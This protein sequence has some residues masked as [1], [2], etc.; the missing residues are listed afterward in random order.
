ML[1]NQNPSDKRK[2][3]KVTLDP[4][5]E[6]IELSIK[7]GYIDSN[8]KFIWDNKSPE[9]IRIQNIPD[10]NINQID[11]DLIVDV[12]KQV[13]LTK[14]PLENNQI[15]IDDVSQDHVS[16]VLVDCSD[17]VENDVVTVSYY[18]SQAG[19]DW[20]NEA[21]IFVR[22]PS[23]D[24]LTDYEYISKRLWTIVLEMGLVQGTLV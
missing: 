4:D 11:S 20:F 5:N 3:S 15:L 19:K 17:N 7:E 9:I 12:N 14:T 1:T 2:I 16:G 21:A 24:G 13:T 10:T 22:D 8:S 18:Y 23:F 6:Y